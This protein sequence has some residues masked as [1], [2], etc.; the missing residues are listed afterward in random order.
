MNKIKAYIEEVSTE[1]IHKVTWPTWTEL[2]SSSIVVMVASLLIAVVI[3][4]MDFCF[5]HIFQ[6]IYGL[7]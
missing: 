1:L 5:Q 6:A 7:F 3:F 2:K 4:V